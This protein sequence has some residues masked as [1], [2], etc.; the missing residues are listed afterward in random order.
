VAERHARGRALREQIPREQQAVWDVLSGRQIPL[1]LLEQQASIRLSDLVPLRYQRILASPRAFLRGAAIVI[2]SDL[3]HTPTTGI[4]VQLCG[5]CHL[6]N[7]G[8]YGSPSAP[9]FLISTTSTR[10]SLVLGNGM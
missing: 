5:D 4:T 10:R 3:G 1:E 6:A 2:A 9:C 8:V 7:F